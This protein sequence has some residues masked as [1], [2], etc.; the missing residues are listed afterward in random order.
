MVNMKTTTIQLTNEQIQQ[1]DE[2][3]KKLRISK[4]G[5]IRMALTR[6]LEGGFNG[7]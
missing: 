5:I 7:C 6:F 4:A 2:Q 3:K 1:L